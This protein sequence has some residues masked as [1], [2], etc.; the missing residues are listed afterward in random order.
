MTGGD[1]GRINFYDITSKERVKKVD[2]GEI[3]LTAL[4]QSQERGFIAAGNNNGAV[5]IIN[6][7]K[8]TG[9]KEYILSLNPHHRLVR[10]LCFIDNDQKLLSASD[11]GSIG[12]VDI[13]S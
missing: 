6:I 5:Y 10:E 9:N 11:D 4:A 8:S 12:M 7:N 13:S 2:V 1:Y 3:F